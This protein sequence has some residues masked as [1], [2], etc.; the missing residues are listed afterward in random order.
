LNY[1]RERNGGTNQETG[2]QA[3]TRSLINSQAARLARLLAR[4]GKLHAIR[5]VLSL[6]ATALMLWQLCVA[7]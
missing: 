3:T 4:W 5:T 1:E 6:L 2:K 7:I